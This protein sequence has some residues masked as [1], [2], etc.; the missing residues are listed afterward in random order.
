MNGEAVTPE[1]RTI[2]EVCHQLLDD[3]NRWFPELQAGI[4][5]TLWHGVLTR[6]HQQVE[7]LLKA[8]ASCMLAEAGDAGPAAVAA[9]AGGKPVAAMTMG[10]H[11]DL[12]RRLGGGLLSGDDR[13]LLD[14]LTELRNDFV[15]GRLPREQGQAK[16]VEFLSLAQE[17]CQSRLLAVISGTA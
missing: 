7:A 15:H 16:T 6:A 17:L 9:V 13:R 4:R 14:R 3:I 1:G 12:V 11:V 2:D 5:S 8:C 10:Q